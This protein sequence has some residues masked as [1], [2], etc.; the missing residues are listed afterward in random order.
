MLVA[1]TGA[2]GFIAK[3]LCK[4]LISNGLS[5]RRIQR[6]SG[7]DEHIFQIESIDS[8]TDWTKALSNV[9]VIVHCASL[10]HQPESKSSEVINKYY[11]INSYGTK[12]L[13][14]Q[15]F[16][17][18]VK[19][20]IF[21]SSIKVNGE[22]TNANNL[23]DQESR[24]FPEDAY[25]QSKLLAEQ[26]LLDISS[27]TG[28]EVIIIRPPLVYGPGVGANFEKLL[29]LI[30]KEYPLP[31]GKFKNRRSLIFVGNL[32]SFITRCIQSEKS[33]GR[34]LLICDKETI[35]TKVLILSLANA[36][37]KRS[38]IFD[39]PLY[40]LYFISFILR[41]RSQLRRLTD[42]LEINPQYSYDC[43]EWTPP[44]DFKTALDITANWYLKYRQEESNFK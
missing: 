20:F 19:R 35:S 10:V 16:K 25:S 36:M 30:Y 11:E 9:D 22:R 32:V 38:L 37:K 41:R 14:E 1:V 6:Q 43:L 33:V 23:F 8:C 26:Y 17:L 28:L 24:P 42:S 3:H 2:N 31:F 44:Y 15:A 27:R 39:V 29:S 5:L 12:N 40:L 21:I 13:A 7:L 18:G 4:Y 34:I